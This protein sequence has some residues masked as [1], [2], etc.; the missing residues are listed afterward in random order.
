MELV[1]LVGYEALEVAV[2]D[3]SDHAAVLFEIGHDL[4]NALFRAV[5]ECL[6]EVGPTERVGHPGHAGLVGE[7]LLR[8]Q[9][10]RR[11]FLTRQGERLVPRRGEHRLDTPE[12]GAMDS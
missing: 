3:G 9:R 10:E 12:H 6:D 7:D 4:D 5:G 1:R 11:G 8:A 2:L